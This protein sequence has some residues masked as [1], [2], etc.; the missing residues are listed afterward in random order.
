M[1]SSPIAT[2]P[3]RTVSD[4]SRFV[5]LA[6]A[7]ADLLLEVDD[8]GLIDWAAGA[9]V[10]RF[11]AAPESFVG[12]PL[13]ELILPQD[14]AAL[15]L[16]VAT[17]AGRGRAPPVTLRLRDARAT[18]CSLAVLKRLGEASGICV[19]IGAPPTTAPLR[20]TDLQD[21]AGFVREIEARLRGGPA[22]DMGLVEVAGWDDLL[23]DTGGEK[24]RAMVTE[25]G[26]RLAEAAGPDAV[27]ALL[28]GGRF[29][30]VGAGH[31]DGPAL[32]EPVREVLRQRGKS[33]AHVNGLSMSVC[34]AGLTVPQSVR[35]MR[36]ALGRFAV[37]GAAEVAE[38]GFSNGLEGFV[39]ATQ[40]R[41]RTVRLAIAEGRFRLAYQPLV[42]LRDRVLHHYE[43][44]LRPISTPN[45]RFHDTSDFVAF[46]EAVGLSEE[47]D[48]AVACSALAAIA[49]GPH[50]AVNLSGLSVQSEAFRQ[51]LLALI[52]SMG[53]GNGRLLVELTETAEIDNV[54]AA[55][56]T[57][58]ALRDRHVEICID[59][60]GAGGA[61]F[62]YLRDFRPQLVKIDGSFVQAAVSSERDRAFIVSM[63]Q[64][65]HSQD[66]EVAAE[67]IETEEVAALMADLGI[68]FGQGWL[69][70][71]PGAL[72]GSLGR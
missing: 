69:F 32:S 43:A 9:F 17:A 26:E 61:A 72:P 39:E 64:L 21:A 18:P 66:A 65:A 36:F 52:D 3:I 34:A 37:G 24:R 13:R 27:A 42:G 44:L 59:D 6:F 48:Y 71:R 70:G 16:A 1:Q 41:A 20:S 22:A 7:H 53:T 63:V 14:H 15:A 57:L 46:A 2:Q 19:S 28:S 55:R 10:S 23:A 58:D 60:F 50:V 29:A 68:A 35:A 30:V 40:E 25:I 12:R 62:R 4:L 5:S 49:G 33:S 31:L 38:A 45:S 8:D 67:V 11:G 51:R 56:A 47:L 54:E